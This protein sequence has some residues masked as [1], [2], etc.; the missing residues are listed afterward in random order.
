MRG[1]PEI[2]L[3]AVESLACGRPVVTTEVLEIAEI[4]KE[5][6]CGC[7]AKPVKEDFISALVECK[8]NYALYQAN[9]RRVAEELFN[10]DEIPLTSKK[11][12]AKGNT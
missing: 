2:P 1:G 11:N 9:C 3:S 8:K 5:Y 6:Q 4:V 7:V 12:T 10:C